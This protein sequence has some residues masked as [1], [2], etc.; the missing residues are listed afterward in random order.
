[1]VRSELKRDTL[2]RNIK[3]AIARAQRENLPATIKEIY[4]FG[5]ILRGKEKAHDFDAIFVYDQ[6]LEQEARWHWFRS[7]FGYYPLDEAAKMLDADQ[8]HKKVY[9]T[10]RLCE[11]ENI[12]LRKAVTIDSVAEK[13]KSMGIE[14]SWAGCFSW[15]EVFYNH[16]GLFLPS[17]EK[18]LRTILCRGM[19]GIQ[20][21]FENYDSFKKGFTWPAKNFRLAWSPEKLDL[22]KNLELR[23]EEKVAFLTNE[24]KLFIEQLAQL[25]EDFSKIQ[26]ELTAL[27]EN[28]GIKLNFE[29]LTSKHV[30]LSYSENDPCD[31]L[32]VKCEQ[33]RQ[34]M[35]TYREETIVIRNLLYATETFQ[36]R[37]RDA[38]YSRHPPQDYVTYLTILRTRKSDVKEKRIREILGDLGLPQDHIVTIRHVDWTDHR[39]E[40]DETK[41]KELVKEARI[42][43]KERKL[44]FKLRNF[45]RKIEPKATAYV[46]L[47]DEAKAVHFRIHCEPA[48][49]NR[50][51]KLFMKKWGKKGFKVTQTEWTLRAVKNF[52][53]TGKETLSYIE[54]LL[55]KALGASKPT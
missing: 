40:S 5:G 55:V 6:T 23:P 30:D 28:V 25:K 41:R 48:K 9:A 35:R 21:F 29:G 18:V 45:V 1:M 15:T 26:N 36:E 39:L 33:A 34:E 44:T 2:I 12:S 19:K 50:M 54:Q 4:A 17:I 32:R 47:I 16:Y 8:V 42:A 37:K 3:H 10:L 51:N 27:A 14:P 31:Q 7:C 22:E 24:L 11:K 53:L 43:E 52:E 49:D 13:L 20:V 38:F 46:N